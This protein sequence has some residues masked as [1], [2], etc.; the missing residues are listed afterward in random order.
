MGRRAGL[1]VV[2]VGAI[3][4]LVWAGVEN[5]RAR[6]AAMLA[7]SPVITL[8]RDGGG[9]GADLVAPE[10]ESLKGRAAPGFTLVD[11][12]GK[13]VS[14]SDY[15]GHPVI[16]N[17]WATWCGPCKLEMP[18]FQEFSQK[19]KNDGLVILGLSQDDGITGP[20]AASAAKRIGVTYP[21]LLPDNGTA[22]AY[23]GVDYLPETFYVSGNGTVV[24]ETA[25]APSKDQMEAMI[26]QTIAASGGG[27][28][29]VAASGGEAA[30]AL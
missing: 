30:G 11:T 23:G 7:H 18:W 6:R 15:R 14:L 22:K 2:L 26:Q 20:E 3:C 19:Y 25:G 5:M 29:A 28:T 12:A 24:E 8:Q 27:K 21:I 9:G 13:R 1:M 16:V 10:G 17:F 4:L